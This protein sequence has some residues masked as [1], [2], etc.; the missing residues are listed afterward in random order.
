MCLVSGLLGVG[1]W[2][3]SRFLEEAVGAVLG[4]A[5]EWAA[6]EEWQGPGVPTEGTGGGNGIRIR[7]ETAGREAYSI[8]AVTN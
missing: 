1:T 5:G 4:S 2:L 3:T 8:A 7:E 6:L